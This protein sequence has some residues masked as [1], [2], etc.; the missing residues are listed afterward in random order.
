MSKGPYLCPRDLQLEEG[1]WKALGTLPQCA[2]APAGTG[3]A[4]VRLEF[5]GPPMPQISFFPSGT[6]LDAAGLQSC[7]AGRLGALR[8]SLPVTHMIVSF[9]FRMAAR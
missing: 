7:L 4:D 9:R 5:V 1:V 3:H 2:T 8:T 6:D